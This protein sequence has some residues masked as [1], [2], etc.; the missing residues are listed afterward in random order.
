MPSLPARWFRP[1]V[2]AAQQARRFRPALEVLEE[3]ETPSAGISGFAF[4]DLNNNG[5]F[6]PGESA[7]AGSAI[8]LFNSANQLIGSTTTDAGGFYRFLSDSSLPPTQQSLTRSLNFDPGPTNQA[9]TRLLPGFDPSLGT[10]LRVELTFSGTISSQIRAENLDPAA[11]MIRGTVQGNVLLTSAG[12]NLRVDADPNVQTYAAAA[13]D[14]VIDFAGASGVNFGA[15]SASGSAQLT[16]TDPI[17]LGMFLN[18]GGVTLTA[19]PF[20]ESSTSG[21]GNLVSQVSSTG[22]GELFVKYVYLT[23]DALRLGTYRVVQPM[24]P[25]GYLDGKFSRAGVVLPASG[26]QRMIIVNYD[27]QSEAAHNDFGS[28]R[29]SSISGR[30]Y[31]DL[32]NDGVWQNAEAGIVGVVIALSGTDDLG[33]TVALT[34][35]TPASGAYQFAGLRPGKY[36]VQQ[37][38]PLGYLSGR[39]NAPGSL[40]GSAA[41]HAFTSITA[42]SAAVGEHY[43]FGWLKPASL[44]G[45]LYADLNKNGSLDDGDQGV[46]NLV[47]VLKG[48]D[49]LGRQVALKTKSDVTG[50]YEFSGLRP[51]T[52][53]IQQTQT[54]RGLKRAGVTIGSSGGMTSTSAASDIQLGVGDFGRDYNFAFRALTGGK[55]S[56]LGS[57]WRDLMGL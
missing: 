12:P 39:V 38:P 48:L 24:T 6:D 55:S 11:A 3:R 56:F 41:A 52:Y 51:G 46:K 20:A 30:V 7:I 44:G 14:G 5:L 27:G 40:G 33:R 45:Y 53:M 8:Q 15:H 21:G 54:P 18:A 42:S 34:Q 4:H 35:T 26:A 43:N 25:A 32:N 57:V 37:S 10:L 16:V 31:I 50:Y 22:G 49:D 23:S 28:L 9:I 2:R 36:A 47:V 13:Y 19:T 17:L 1:A 29:P